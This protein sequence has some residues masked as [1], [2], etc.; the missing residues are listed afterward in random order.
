MVYT[1][2]ISKNAL[3]YFRRKA[4]AIP[5]EIQAYLIGEFNYPDKIIVDSIIHPKYYAIQ[6]TNN[7]QPTADEFTRVKLLAERQ[8]KRII[9]D[10]HSHPNSEPIMSFPDYT[11][12]LEDG[13]QICGIVGIKNG[14]TDVKFWTQNSPL[15]CEVSY[16]TCKRTSDSTDK[17]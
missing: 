6:T 14:K 8:G 3:D 17:D 1:V 13:L 4:R 15:P 7:V 2:H 12:C 5:V 9:G 16:E 10:I 11:S